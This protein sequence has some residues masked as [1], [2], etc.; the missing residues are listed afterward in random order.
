[1]RKIE[2]EEGEGEEGEGEVY[3]SWKSEFSL[4]EIEYPFSFNVYKG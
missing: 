4:I 2:G 3:M 1:M